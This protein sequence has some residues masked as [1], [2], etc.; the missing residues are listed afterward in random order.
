MYAGHKSEGG[1][2]GKHSVEKAG[3]EIIY[4]SLRQS[5]AFLAMQ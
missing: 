5:A 4:I 2:V 3:R 1:E